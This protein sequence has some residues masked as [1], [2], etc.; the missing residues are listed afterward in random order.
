MLLTGA[1][2]LIGTATLAKLLA[3]SHEVIA[4]ARIAG[5]SAPGLRWVALDLRHAGQ[6]EQWLPHLAGVDAVINCAGVLQDSV[7]DSTRA[8]HTSGPAA[9][10]AACARAGVRR[11]IHLS[12]IGVDRETPSEFSRT[13]AAGDENLMASGLDWVILRPSVVIGCGAY[14]GSA[15]FRGLAALPV[16]PRVP[17]AGALQVVHLDD[18][19]ATIL[20]FLRPDAPARIELELAGPQRLAFDEV[21][22]AFR[23]WLGW[24]PARKIN[25]PRWMMA[26]LYR[27]GDFAGWL[28]W[29]PPVRS[30]AQREIVR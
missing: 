25:V 16:L 10:F 27:L 5:R 6:P 1:T 22:A 7:R 18:V 12:A 9:L 21:I 2:G 17:D 11:V 3:E 13:K 14:G 23:Q 20:W 26:I 19:V 30:T 28:G 8:A 4:V 15:L 29:R 24:S